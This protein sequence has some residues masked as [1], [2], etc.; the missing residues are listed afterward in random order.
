M[1]LQRC[2]H[3]DAK[4]GFDFREDTSGACGPGIY[5]MKFGDY[6]MRK[7]YSERG[8]KT[9]SFDVPDNL[10]KRIGGRGVTTYW[11]IR[12]AIFREKENGFKVFICKHKGINIPTSKQYVIIDASVISNVEEI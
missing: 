4:D 10:V 3:G 8:E 11:A 1:K 7:Y 12:E 6:P 5:A 2:Q 9:F